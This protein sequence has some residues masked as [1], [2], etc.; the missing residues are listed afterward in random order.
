[1]AAN[2]KSASQRALAKDRWAAMEA[3]KLPEWYAMRKLEKAARETAATAESAR[4]LTQSDESAFQRAY[5]GPSI[6][7]EGAS[8]DDRG[9]M[10]WRLPLSSGSNRHTPS[11]N[12]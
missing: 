3:G 11:R 4:A 6:T 12:F 9:Y 2:R 5:S 8:W 7:P 1:V 10:V